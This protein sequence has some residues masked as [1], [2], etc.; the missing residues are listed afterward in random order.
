MA[1]E[2]LALTHKETGQEVVF[3][4]RASYLAA[5]YDGGHDIAEVPPEQP[6]AAPPPRPVVSPTLRPEPPAQQ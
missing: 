4:D 1:D 2:R 3:G 5:L 6:L